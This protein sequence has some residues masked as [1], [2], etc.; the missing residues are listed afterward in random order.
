MTN[1]A[2]PKPTIPAPEVM[3]FTTE[4]EPSL[5]IIFIYLV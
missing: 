4:V 1:M 2:M 3:K 5:V